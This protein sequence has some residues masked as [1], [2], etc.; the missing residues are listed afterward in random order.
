VLR[1]AVRAELPARFYQLLQLAVPFAVQF[2]LGGRWRWAAWGAATSAFGI[3][4]LCV[5]RHDHGADAG[6]RLQALR[7]CRVACG[8]LAAVVALALMLEA[9]LHVMGPGPIS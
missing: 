6:W 2:A 3:W 4:G 5:Q 7:V 8:T 1:Q 9:F